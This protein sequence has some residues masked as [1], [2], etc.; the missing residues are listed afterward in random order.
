MKIR[1]SPIEPKPIVQSLDVIYDWKAVVEGSLFPLKYHSLYNSFRR[2]WES[3][4][5]HLESLP[6][7][8]FP[9]MDL[10]E[11]NFQENEIES[12][13][14]LTKYIQLKLSSI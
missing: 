9:K 11:L 10:T 8:M 1:I 7:K 12:T 5:K 14:N 13:Y 4:K 2:E 6:T 3:L